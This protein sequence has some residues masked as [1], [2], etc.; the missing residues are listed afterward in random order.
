[1]A[2]KKLIFIVLGIIILVA[3]LITVLVTKNALIGLCGCAGVVAV[4]LYDPRA[5]TQDGYCIF[6]VYGGTAVC[7]CGNFAVS[8][9]QRK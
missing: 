4:D 3:V 6:A 1:M 7:G 8:S 5:K 9:Y 2:D